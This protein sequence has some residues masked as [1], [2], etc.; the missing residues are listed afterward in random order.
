M[1]TVIYALDNRYL[2]RPG[3][4]TV[5]KTSPA[6]VQPEL[7]RKTH[8]SNPD[9]NIPIFLIVIFRLLPI[10]TNNLLFLLASSLPSIIPF[11]PFT[12]YAF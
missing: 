6:E 12:P 11:D 9:K 10:K 4:S 5:V 1:T 2:G 3:T 7:Q 8:R